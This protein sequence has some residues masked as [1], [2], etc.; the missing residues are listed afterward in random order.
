VELVIDISGDVVEWQDLLN[1]TRLATFDGASP[2][3]AWSL[4]GSVSWDT[5]SGSRATEGDITLA[6]ADGSDLFGTLAAGEV[7]EMGED[8]T[9]DAGHAMRLEYDIDGGSGEFASATGTATAQGSLSREEFHARWV[10]T[11][12]PD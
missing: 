1:G 8:D 3:G 7:G 6:R 9:P 5:R 12:A 4:S 2:D 10:I 11:L